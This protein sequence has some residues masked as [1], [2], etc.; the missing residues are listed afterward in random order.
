MDRTTAIVS[1]AAGAAAVAS[2]ITLALFFVAGGPLGTVNDILNGV[3]AV[4]SGYLAWRLSG[5]SLGTY[6]ALLGEVIAIIGS[7]LVI[8]NSTGF[9]FAGLVS[10]VGFALIGVWLVT[11]CWSLA[12]TTLRLLGLIAGALLVIGLAVVPGIAVRLDDMN[13]APAW[14]WIGFVSWLGIYAAYPAW[15]IWSGLSHI[16]RA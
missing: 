11:Y 14:I 5:P 12:P 15:A 8:T 7:V 1:V 3:L 10:T 13:K 16:A 6:V 9:F 2:A 4:L